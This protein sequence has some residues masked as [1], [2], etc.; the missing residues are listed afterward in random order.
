MRARARARERESESERGSRSADGGREAFPLVS[1]DGGS[2]HCRNCRRPCGGCEARRAQPDGARG[3][4]QGQWQWVSRTNRAAASAKAAPNSKRRRE[5]IVSTERI[6]RGRP[7]RVDGD[8]VVFSVL[9]L[10]SPRRARRDRS[11]TRHRRQRRVH[12]VAC[13]FRCRAIGAGKRTDRRPVS[14][15]ALTVSPLIAAAFAL[16]ARRHAYTPSRSRRESLRRRR[17]RRRRNGARSV[18]CWSCETRRLGRAE[19]SVLSSVHVSRVETRL[20]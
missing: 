3:W 19:I 12:G 18:Y 9:S 5:G 4:A 7:T 16:Y 6:F 17:R 13:S 14:E 11:V 15:P 20:T 10:V 8:G 1:T 2:G